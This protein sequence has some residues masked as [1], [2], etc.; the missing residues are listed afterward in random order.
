MKY[1][2][3]S[4]D[5]YAEIPLGGVPL[6]GAETLG[7][8]KG[9]PIGDEDD[10]PRSRLLSGFLRCLRVLLK[11]A[12]VLLALAV[13]LALRAAVTQWWGNSSSSSSS[14]SN[15]DDGSSSSGG[16]TFTNAYPTVSSAAAYGF[17]TSAGATLAVV[18]PGVATTVSF[19]SYTALNY[20]CEWTITSLGSADVFVR[21]GCDDFE[22]YFPAA[23]L[24]YA[25]TLRWWFSAVEVP[26]V[27]EVSTEVRDSVGGFSRSS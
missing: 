20:E 27:H 18:E 12:L 17:T 10:G 6:G 24:R 21:Y 23:P 13:L 16:I 7:L 15:D 26:F 19:G 11:V 25:V 9:F 22:Y 5:E 1:S 8:V 14:S 4:Q 3:V 2:A